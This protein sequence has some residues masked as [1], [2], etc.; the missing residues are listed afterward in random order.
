MMDVQYL[1]LDILSHEAFMLFYNLKNERYH[2]KISFVRRERLDLL[3][4]LSY[5]RFL[6]RVE[7]YLL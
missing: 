3:I 6:R 4:Y 7:A 5:L 2:S 1:E